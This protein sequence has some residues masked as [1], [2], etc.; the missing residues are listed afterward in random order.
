MPSLALPNVVTSAHA[1]E[2][3]RQ[4]KGLLSHLHPPD[5]SD[6]SHSS[7]SAVGA[8]RLRV[9]RR[10]EISEVA[11]D[12]GEGEGEGEEARRKVAMSFANWTTSRPMIIPDSSFRGE[13]GFGGEW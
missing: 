1:T 8:T 3:G 6:K 2:Q 9:Q 10:P 7:L 11:S 5:V 13:S 12:E 4:P